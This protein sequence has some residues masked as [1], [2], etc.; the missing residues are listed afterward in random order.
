MES[1]IAAVWGAALLTNYRCGEWP[2]KRDS[3]L[4]TGP[5]ST[6][7]SPSVAGATLFIYD[8]LIMFPAEVRACATILVGAIHPLKSRLKKKSTGAHFFDMLSDERSSI[9]QQE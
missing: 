1:L 5:D 4:I 2:V 3:I 6:L 9:L 7:P 8:S